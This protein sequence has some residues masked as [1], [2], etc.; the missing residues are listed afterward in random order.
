ML[1]GQQKEGTVRNEQATD[2]APWGHS[3]AAHAHLGFCAHCPD[4]S[5]AAEAI[6]WRTYAQQGR[7]GRWLY[8]RMHNRPPLQAREG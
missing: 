4:Q 2:N 7:L 3:E 1:C 5:W 6:G 8:R